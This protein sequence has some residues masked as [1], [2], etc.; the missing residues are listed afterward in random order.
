MSDANVV[1]QIKKC[2]FFKANLLKFIKLTDGKA[3]CQ[4]SQKMPVFSLDFW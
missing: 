4:I 1:G 3:A 2:R